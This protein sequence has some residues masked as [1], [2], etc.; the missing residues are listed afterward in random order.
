MIRHEMKLLLSNRMNKILLIFLF[1]IA[2]SFSIFA[3][4][5]ISFVDNNGNTH[6]GIFAPRKLSEK[7]S[8]YAGKLNP[9]V[10][11]DVI[12]KDKKIKK[13]KGTENS[14]FPVIVSEAEIPISFFNLNQ[15]FPYNLLNFFLRDGFDFL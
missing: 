3:A 7:K 4:W 8:K 9:D 11:E 6:N 15:I 12:K 1:A 14:T 13:R 10:F 5:S 2:V